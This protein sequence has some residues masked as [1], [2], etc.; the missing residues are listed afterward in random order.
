[1]DVKEAGRREG[2][3]AHRGDGL[4]G[5]FRALAGLASSGPSAAVFLDGRPHEVLGDEL[6]RHLDSGVTEGM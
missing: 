5:G 6:S 3:V 4:A 1:V 2:E